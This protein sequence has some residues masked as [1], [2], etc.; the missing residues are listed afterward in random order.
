M[1]ITV[2]QGAFL[3]VPPLRGGAVE[4]IW[5]AL[6]REFARRGH[7][8]THISRRF[9]GLPDS[10]MRDGVRHIRVRGHDTPRRLVWLKALDLFYSL[11]VRRV[12]P[13]ADILVTNT[14]WLP[15]L[16][17]SKKRGALYVHVAR[18]PK[19]QM[20]FYKH[21]ARLQGV[22]EAVR[23]AILAEV[24]ALAAKVCAV[25]NPL[26]D[27]PSGPPAPPI[28]SRARHLL[29]AG[30]IHPEKGI[31][32]LV[33]AV[34]RLGDRLPAEWRLLLVG[35]W[36]AAAGG[37]GEGYLAELRRLAQP[38]GDRVEF[39][40]PT[41]DSAQ[42]GAHYRAARLFVYPSLAEKGETFGVAPLEAMSHGCPALVSDLAC[43]RDFLEEDVN[44][45]VFDHRAND[46][47][48]TLA[49]KIHA[50][51]AAPERLEAAGSRAIETA[52]RF[53][54]E[55]VAGLYLEDFQSLL[56][57]PARPAP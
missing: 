57:S 44:G 48:G 23:Q 26:S 13:A 35:P 50:L 29:Y 6:G 54:I 16:V 10:E 47:A 5:F 17:R 18:Y 12:L 30:R 1:K 39:A 22:S 31:H 8:V 38:L 34:A 40:G 52:A 21:A 20:R 11:R 3:P 7:E 45:F 36:D 42:L 24:P 46:P 14:F 27:L 32:L 4:K 43:F 28:A 56:S 55:R 41:Y 37:G 19:G 25:P 49:E 53:S 15:V 51:L 2:A 33:E 9:P